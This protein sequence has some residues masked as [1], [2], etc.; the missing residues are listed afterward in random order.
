MR[1]YVRHAERYLKALSG[2]RL[3]EHTRADVT[4]YLK[5]EV[6]GTVRPGKAA[7]SSGWDPPSG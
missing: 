1:W 4:G 5:F 6:Q 7:Y 2:E 3:A